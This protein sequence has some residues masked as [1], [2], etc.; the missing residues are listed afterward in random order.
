VP[1]PSSEEAAVSES[2][3][4]APEAATPADEP[5]ITDWLQNVAS[6]S[7]DAQ[8]EEPSTE[9]AEETAE[10]DL[11]SWLAGLDDDMEQPQP[12]RGSDDDL[13]SWLRADVE[14]EPVQAEPT[15]P[16]DWKPIDEVTAYQE[17]PP[18]PTPEP[19]PK[20]EEAPVQAPTPPAPE[21]KVEE[22]PIQAPPPPAQEPKPEPAPEREP[23][24]EPVTRS[25]SGMTGMLSAAQNPALVEA[26]NELTRSNIPAAMDNYSKLI[27][28]G[29][30]L[31]E[32]IYDLRE[33]MYRFPVEVSILQTLGDAYMRANRL[34]DALDAYTKAEELLR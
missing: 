12:A 6:E 31:D 3:Q 20:A 23:Y 34:Q 22:A 1:A 8:V 21:P 10:N 15:A 4:E 30:L 27:K 25:R 26:Q 16:A 18:A 28:K 9:P 5:G 7:S 11:P 17:E 14:Q 29:K 24:R 32:I 33:A 19:E 13:P 2:A